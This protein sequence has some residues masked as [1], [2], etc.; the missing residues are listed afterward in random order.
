MLLSFLTPALIPP[1]LAG[2]SAVTPDVSGNCQSP[3]WSPDGSTLAYE[4][5]YH[6]KK[7]IETWLVEDGKPAVRVTP[8]SRGASAVTSGFQTAADRSVVHELTWGPEGYYLY[9][10]SGPD[11]N[12]DLYLNSGSPIAPGPAADGGPAWSPDGRWIAFTSARTGQ[13][14]VYLLGAGSLEK[15]PT[16]V[17]KDADASEL[18][19]AWS[20]DSTKLA[21]VGHTRSGD[22]I[23]VVEDLAN[24]VPKKLVALGNTQTRPSFSPDGKSLAFYT[25]HQEKDRFDLFVLSLDSG[26]S[27]PV[28]RG[29]VMNHDGAQ[30]LPDGS[31]ILYVKDD[32]DKFDPVYIATLATGANEAVPT[33]TVGNGD[34]DLVSDGGKLKLAVSAQ[35]LTDDEVRDFKRV[36][37]YEL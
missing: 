15:D 8:S 25:N 2:A 29:V 7:V 11:Q 30:W 32:D 26:K 22:T 28:A 10:A 20:G 21:W 13:G 16:R 23:H 9:A 35:G 24:P 36:Y 18:Y 12:Y 37:V 31:G 1:A 14:D 34:H 3:S 4:L 19:L 33:G 6:D 27:R 5:N 17:S